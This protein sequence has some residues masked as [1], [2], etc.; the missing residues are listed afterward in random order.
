MSSATQQFNWRNLKGWKRG[1]YHEEQKKR[2]E[3]VE[4]EL[5]ET[6]AKQKQKM[7]IR[8]KQLARTKLSLWSRSQESEGS[9]AEDFK[10][11]EFIYVSR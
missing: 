5:E 8:K 9:E 2:A 3:K 1:R 11:K 4:K 10:W 6:T 7:V